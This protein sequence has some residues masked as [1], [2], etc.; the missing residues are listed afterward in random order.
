MITC[1]Y[2]VHFLFEIQYKNNQNIESLHILYDSFSLNIF[3]YI[4]V[5]RWRTYRVETS[6]R[7][8]RGKSVQQRPCHAKTQHQE[9]CTTPLCSSG[10]PKRRRWKIQRRSSAASS[11]LWTTKGSGRRSGPVSAR[12]SS[13][14]AEPA[15]WSTELRRTPLLIAGDGNGAALFPSH[16]SLPCFVTYTHLTVTSTALSIVNQQT[17][18]W[19]KKD[20]VYS[21]S[22]LE[23]YHAWRTGSGIREGGERWKLKTRDAWL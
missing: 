11:R 19:K 3:L 21:K 8:W 15:P 6:R 23:M 2:L 1:F 4:N 7:S 16:H 9:G 5:D 14:S 17:Y 12:R 18:W 13:L 22:Q 20:R 10:S